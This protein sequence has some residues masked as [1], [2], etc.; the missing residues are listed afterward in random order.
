MSCI[1]LSVSIG[2]PNHVTYLSLSKPTFNLTAYPI[3]FIDDKEIKFNQTYVRY[4]LCTIKLLLIDYMTYIVC[5]FEL[6]ERG[7]ERF[8]SYN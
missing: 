2:E 8:I 4:R 6:I 5:S 3:L 7:I 1:Y